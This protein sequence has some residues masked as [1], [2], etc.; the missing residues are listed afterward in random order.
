MVEAKNMD[1]SS[2]NIADLAVYSEDR[3]L[4]LIIEV[5]GRTD[6][7]AEW[8]AELR[9][10]LLAYELL[11]ANVPY[12][13]IAAP[14]RFFLWKGASA[15]PADSEAIVPPDYTIGAEPLLSAYLAYPPPD[16]PDEALRRLN[17]DALTIAIIPWL[18]NLLGSSEAKEDLYNRMPWV[19]DSGL[20]EAIK[21]GRIEIE[22]LV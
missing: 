20:Y 13:L 21:D 15:A 17:S 8:A 4:Q 2:G 11:P 12:F 16:A 14:Y 19:F 6:A 7:T 1:T 22:A 5:K 3:R 9:R 18:N 10:N